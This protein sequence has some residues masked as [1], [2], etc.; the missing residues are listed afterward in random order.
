MRRRSRGE[1]SLT[2]SRR[3]E[4]LA[5]A[6]R[7]VER[8]GVAGVTVTA[9]AR[10]AGVTPA[11]LYAHFPSKDHLLSHLLGRPVTTRTARSHK[12]RKQI[13]DAAARLLAQKGY[14]ETSLADIAADL[15]VSQGTL[16]R[17]F[18]AK[19][20]LFTAILRETA[21]PLVLRAEPVDD[22]QPLEAFFEAT[23]RG[24]M[25]SIRQNV[26]TYRLIF[27]EGLRSKEAAD[28]CYQALWA[29]AAD[30]LTRYLERHAHRQGLPPRP[31]PVVARGFFGMISFFMIMRYLYGGVELGPVPYSDGEIARELTRVFVGGLR[32]GE[33]A[34]AEEP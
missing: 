16:Y 4:I 32:Q 25:D 1:A 22:H 23:A 20:T 19:A 34:G 15:G 10:E 8:Q 26:S 28:L 24:L 9:I 18:D 31:W 27:A 30:Q 21:Y 33:A 5:A 12:R 11:A 14:A 7:V 2:R 6:R 13:L 17:Y 29:D 3:A